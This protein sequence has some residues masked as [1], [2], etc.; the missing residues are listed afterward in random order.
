LSD[1][2]AGGESIC[3]ALIE[4]DAVVAEDSTGLLLL[5]RESEARG[6][7]FRYD[8][9]N[10]RTEKNQCEETILRQERY[11]ELGQKA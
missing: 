8:L 4:G 6:I 3:E 10:L 2:G 11:K 9:C 7:W 5:S 1:L